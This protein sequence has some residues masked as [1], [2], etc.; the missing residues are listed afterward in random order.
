MIMLQFCKE[1]MLTFI[2][3]R[4]LILAY[5]K[6]NSGYFIY[7]KIVY[8]IDNNGKMNKHPDSHTLR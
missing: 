6:R 2:V 3:R 4:E 5:L 7:L 1:Q 8:C